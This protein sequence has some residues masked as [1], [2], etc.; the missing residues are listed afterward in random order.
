MVLGGILKRIYNT[1]TNLYEK[2]KGLLNKITPAVQ[3]YA[4]K[5]GKIIRQIGDASGYG[6]ISTI[7]RGIENIAPF[8][9]K[10][11]DKIGN[12]TIQ[13]PSLPT[14]V[15]PIDNIYTKIMSS[16]SKN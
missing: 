8:I 6:Y 9:G 15:V 5:I 11:N 16:A 3:K 7:G 4:P 14:P 10:I 12:S 2:G 1:S 13:K